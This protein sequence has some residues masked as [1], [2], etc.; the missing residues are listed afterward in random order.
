[1]KT[2]NDFTELNKTKGAVLLLG[3][4][5]TGKTTLATQLPSPYFITYDIGNLRGPIDYIKRNNLK[6]DLRWDS[7]YEDKDGKPIGRAARYQR[8]ADL[9]NAAMADASVKTIV[10]DSLTSLV[11]IALDEVRR[12]QGW[13]MADGVKNLQDKNFEKQGWGPFAALLKHFII[14]QKASGKLIVF[15]G[16][17]DTRFDED[18]E[19]EKNA[20]LLRYIAVPGQLRSTIAGYFD[21]VWLLETEDKIVGG[22]VESVRY[23]RTLPSTTKDAALGLKTAVGLGRRV[24]LD[25]NEITNALAK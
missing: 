25:F 15:T 9:G 8:V 6:A 12:Q 3:P 7:P 22:V 19:T 20:R 16:H 18:E 13:A 2:L 24:K 21:D 10:N 1:M 17:V 14:T 4:P 5:G 11:D 23:L